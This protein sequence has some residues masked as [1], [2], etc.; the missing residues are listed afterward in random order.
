MVTASLKFSRSKDAPV[1]LYT[2]PDAGRLDVLNVLNWHEAHDDYEWPDFIQLGHDFTQAMR[3]RRGLVNDIFLALE[4]AGVIKITGESGVLGTPQSS[5]VKRRAGVSVAMQIPH[6]ET[7]RFLAK[8]LRCL[9]EYAGFPVDDC[10]AGLEEGDH[11]SEED[12]ANTIKDLVA[13]VWNAED[14]P[15]SMKRVGNIAFSKS[16]SEQAP[17]ISSPEL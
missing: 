10:I 7:D 12:L 15:R 5:A 6:Y 9:I 11:L 3:F 13:Q 1:S 14:D 8:S 16:G 17:R 4:K 2:T